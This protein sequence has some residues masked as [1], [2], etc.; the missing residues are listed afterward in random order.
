MIATI[1]ISVLAFVGFISCVLFFPRIKFCKKTVKSSQTETE[2]VTNENVVS[3]GTEI[4]AV[5]KLEVEN[6]SVVAN[7]IECA[8]EHKVAKK[9]KVSNELLKERK[10]FSLETFWIA[11]LLGAILLLAVSAVSPSDV[12][13]S[14]S[15]N[16]AVNPLKIL[17]L[18][19]SMTIVSV[20]LDEAG[21][22][23]Y[24][25]AKTA[26]RFGGSQNTLFFAL[27]AVISLLTIFTSN[28]IVILTFTPFICYFCKRA[29]IKPLPYLIMEFVAANTW[30]MLLIIGNP[31]NIYLATAL[32]VNF[33]EYTKI[34]ALPTVVAGV[35]SFAIIRL[36]FFKPLKEKITTQS[37]K[38]VLKD[39]TLTALALTTLTVCIIL[40]AVA[41]FVKAMEMWIVAVGSMAVLLVA[42]L[43]YCLAKH[44]KPTVIKNALGRAPWLLIP[45]V[46]SMFIIVLAFSKQGITIAIANFLGS[47][48]AVFKY[49]FLSFVG[50]NILNNIPMSVLFA[51]VAAAGGATV[52]ASYATIIASNI[53]AILTPVGALAGIM[54]TDIIRKNNIKMSIFQFVKYGIFVSI[55]TLTLSLAVLCFFV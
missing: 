14:F 24:F 28:D 21:F 16:S 50:A 20:F 43:I 33:F 52:A 26:I 15:S 18:F 40:L 45:F 44:Q 47:D 27:Y 31:T 4:S 48:F 23:E 37:E 17:A 55:P 53:G 2:K 46:L 34:M 51:E 29:N 7:E 13:T 32:Q 3:N 36:L 22:F 11:P 12:W 25:A 9:L 35:V 42:V 19:F 10:G 5:I 54:W 38:A 39:K 49:G 1:T 30:S 8:K 6:E 41:S